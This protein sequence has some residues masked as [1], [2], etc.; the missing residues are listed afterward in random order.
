MHSRFSFGFL[1]TFVAALALPCAA[2]RA[3]TDSARAKGKP[4]LGAMRR[5][6][7]DVSE[8]TWSNVD[9]SPDGRTLLFDVLGDIYTMPITGGS[10][11]P[12]LTGRDW[13]Q[14]PRYSPDGKSIAFISDRDGN[15]NLWVAQVDGSNPKQLTKE[16]RFAHASPAWARDGTI[17]VR[18]NTRTG[19]ELWAI[20]PDGGTGYKL[21]VSGAIAGPAVSPDGRFLFLSGLRRIDRLTGDSIMLGE[22]V[23]PKVSP[24][25]RL[26]AY[27]RPNDNLTALHLRNLVTGEDRRLVPSI[28]PMANGFTNQD[29]HP[30][31]A[32]TP[33]GRSLVLS[34][35]GKLSRVDVASGAV[36][37]IPMR[38]HVAVDMANPIRV[39][40]RMEDGDLKVHVIRWPS[41]SPDGQRLVF[42]AM[43]RLYGQ[44]VAGGTPQRLSTS[45]DLE[46]TPSYSPDGR[47]IAYTTWSD[48]ALGHVMLMPSKGGAPRRLTTIAGRYA[49]PTWSRDGTRLAFSRGGGIE[50]R[51]GQPEAETYFDL[52]W[53]P[54]EGGGEPRYITSTYASRAIGFPMR[55][56]PVIAFNVDGTRLFYSQWGRASTPGDAARATLYSVRLDGTDRR[57]HIRTIAMDEIVPS[58]DGRQVALVLRE[59]VSIAAMPQYA[60]SV[61]DLNLDAASLPVKKLTTEG[62]NYVTWFDSNTVTWSFTNQIFRQRVDAPAGNAAERVTEVNLTIPRAK[63]AGLIAFTNARL[64]TMKGD[65]V[66]ARGTVVVDGNR[67]TG[68]GP[69]G[70]VRIPAGAQRVDASGKTIVPGFVDVHAHLHYQAFE[71][72]PRQK[73]EYL[74]NLAYG[75]TTSYD[76]SA[77]NLDVFAQQ[78]MVEAGEMMGPRILSSGDAIYGDENVFPV[79]YENIRSI[80]D[81]RAVVKRFKAYD[82]TMLKEYMQPRRD[83]RQWLAQ[84]ARENGVMITAEG[85]GDLVLD[86]TMFADGYSAVEHALPIAPLHEDV[87]EFVRRSGTHY[88]PT[89]IVGY[90]GPTL[91]Q[92]FSQQSRIHDDVKLRRFTPEDQLDRWRR[93]QYVPDEEWH[94]MR[95]SESAAKIS[96][97]GGLVTLGSH[98]N[99][100]GLGAQW[101]LWG[102]QMGGLTNLEALQAATIV[103]ARKIGYDRD[104]GSLEVGKLADFLV[105]D[106]NPLENIRNSARLK[107]TVK[108]GTVYDAES[109]TEVWPRYRPLDRFFWQTPQDQRHFAAPPA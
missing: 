11:T 108:N 50:Q 63:P 77:H 57:A 9:V 6:E 18:R 37:A 56:Y 75:V 25:G 28:T 79:I 58:P 99:R 83:Q 93:W 47:W 60:T 39:D 89:L 67:I 64:V 7:F 88:T 4:D 33:D 82:P 46:Y 40:H 43:G 72:F 19:A 15:M 70:S 22:G 45:P 102:L 90:G 65:Q 2:V 38:V 101:E 32:F 26:L 91:D 21:P 27:V 12:L 94:W 42:S 96:K 74:A 69:S 36:E 55:Y 84:A 52:V 24:D 68:V 41:L 95:I 13:D 100:Q 109:L 107:Y 80:E 29:Q 66:I 14:M 31:Y 54:V 92:Y 17:L 1:A 51:G 97:A 103:A 62:G 20:H 87:I 98:G 61:V 34:I 86:L 30:D 48:T 106:A 23:R 71:T 85:G 10:A 73:W 35:H 53:V 81:A 76:P 104:L 44:D 49:N 16:N 8:S 5:I 3:Q 59:Q 78:E 105:L